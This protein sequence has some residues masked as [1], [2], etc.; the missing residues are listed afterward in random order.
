M[1]DQY[2]SENR[3]ASQWWAVRRLRYNVGLIV[4]GILAFIAYLIVLNVFEDV[5]FASADPSEI[6]VGGLPLIFQSIAYLIMMAVANVCY[7]L[8]VFFERWIN[9]DKVDAYRRITYRIGFW[10]SVLLAFSIPTLLA[11]LAIFYP[12]TW[13]K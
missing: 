7:S 4:A 6:E 8:G 9:H 12:Q 2:I 11:V 10:F 1:F 13:R 3:T 5:I